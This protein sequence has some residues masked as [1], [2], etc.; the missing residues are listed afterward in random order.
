[1]TEVPALVHV[2]EVEVLGEQ[3]LRLTFEDG[4][5]G[6]VEFD[7]NEWRGVLAPLS[8]PDVFAQ[9]RVDSQLGTLVWPGGLD[10]APEPLYEQAIQHLVAQPLYHR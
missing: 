7:T 1:M 10:V 6:D 4:A 2:V 5:V 3:R 8:D 9:V